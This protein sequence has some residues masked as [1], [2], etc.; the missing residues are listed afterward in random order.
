M[1]KAK[2]KKIE[3]TKLILT[4]L[5]KDFITNSVRI[6]ETEQILNNLIEMEMRAEL[7]K[8]K[9]FDILNA[10]KI[11][12]R[13]L[14]L[15]K[16]KSNEI[17]LSTIKD[18][19]GIDFLQNSDRNEYI[20]NFYA[21]IYKDDKS[22]SLEPDAIRNFLGAE[23]CESPV[24]RNNRLTAE[25]SVNF[26]SPLSLNE[27]DI[28]IN[29]LNDKS[30]GGLDGIGT[31]FLKKF[32][33]FIRIP[34]HRCVTTCIHK[35]T[36]SQSF[37]SAIIRLIPKKGDVEKIKNWRPISFLNCVFKIVSKAVDNRLKKINDIVLSRAQKGFTNKRFIQECF[38]NPLVTRRHIC[39]AYIDKFVENLVLKISQFCFLG[40][41][42]LC[43]G[44]NF[45]Q[46]EV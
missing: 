42:R 15:A 7:Y 43:I 39:A 14:S 46:S 34:L 24:V 22:R 25:E 30:A 9:H 3:S 37:N 17:P 11:S 18:D 41:V 5:K 12:P 33:N 21:G 40:I 28:V 8:F 26:D 44:L 45:R 2:F 36:L 6:Q 4:E 16:I 38:I 1:R 35:Q 31:K 32:W 23:I 27:L 10:E 29:Q 13:F 19:N 20:T